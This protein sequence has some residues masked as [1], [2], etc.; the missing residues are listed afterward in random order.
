MKTLEEIKV[1]KKN[2]K[3]ALNKFK[4]QLKQ[5]IPDVGIILYGSKARGDSEEFSDIDLL[6][7][8]GEK[9]TR[10]LRERISHIRYDIELKYDVVFGLILENKEFWHSSLA[11]VMPFYRNVER[12]GVLL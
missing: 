8:V 2:E 5:K 11:N 9:V 12:E 10:E 4:A 6:I 7:I 1:L 3:K